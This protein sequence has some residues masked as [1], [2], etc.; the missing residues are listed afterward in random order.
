MSEMVYS[1]RRITEVLLEGEYLGYEWV[2]ASYGTH[3]CAYVKL[4]NNSKLIPLGEEIPL[5]GTRDGQLP[6][7]RKKYM[8]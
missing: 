6:K 7:Y 2:I 3:P 5:S 8:R 1:N 4:P